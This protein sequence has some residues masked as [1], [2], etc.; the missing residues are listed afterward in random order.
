MLVEAQ[1]GARLGQDGGER[2]LAHL[3]RV[4]AQ[5]ITVQLD[6]VEGVQEHAGV[7]PPIA[8]AVEAWS[9]SQHTA[10]PS[11]MQERERAARIVSRR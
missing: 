4:V 3:E 8:N 2:G 6:Q 5:I 7:V 1:A 11:M 9:S 10:S